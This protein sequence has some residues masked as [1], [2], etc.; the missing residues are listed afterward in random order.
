LGK[1][2]GG[3]KLVVGV[4]V[5]VFWF[6]AADVEVAAAFGGPTSPL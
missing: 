4:G 3:A 1:G 6:D 5:G 2:D